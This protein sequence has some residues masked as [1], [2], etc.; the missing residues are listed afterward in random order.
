[1]GRLLTL[2]TEL[3]TDPNTRGYSGMTPEEAADDL[4]T[5]YATRQITTLSG[6]EVYEEVDIA[7]F[8]ALTVAQQQ[9]VWDIVHLGAVID[10]SAGS[11]ARTRFV[12]LFGV[13]SDTITDLLAKLTVSISRG[14]EIGIGFVTPGDVEGALALGG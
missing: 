8:Q 13:G 5:Q 2:Y 3:S 1:M 4:N 9:E 6:G 10:V 7:E 14:E 11:K 12:S